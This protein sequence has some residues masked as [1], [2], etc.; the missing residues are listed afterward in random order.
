MHGFLCEEGFSSGC[1]G[2]L[3]FAILEVA[4]SRRFREFRDGQW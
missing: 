3:G 1:N 2:P 4:G